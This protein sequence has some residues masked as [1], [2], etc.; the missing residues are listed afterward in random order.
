MSTLA[1]EFAPASHGRR[2]RRRSQPVLFESKGSTLEDLV[3]GV[4]EDLEA[5]SQA[6]CPVCGEE[7]A[8]A[9]DGCSACG[10]SLG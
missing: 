3:L 10:A 6:N 5:H 2:S 4:W 8:L 9:A 1:I 7:A